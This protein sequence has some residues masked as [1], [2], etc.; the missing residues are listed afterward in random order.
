M[1]VRTGPHLCCPSATV[2]GYQLTSIKDWESTN[3]FAGS[4][5]LGNFFG[6]RAPSPCCTAGGEWMLILVDSPV[7]FESLVVT[8][9]RSGFSRSR[10]MRPAVVLAMRA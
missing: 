4:G 2:L 7:G 1:I 3:R 8:N 5:R 6:D 10:A 9:A